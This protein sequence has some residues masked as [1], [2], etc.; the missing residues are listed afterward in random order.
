[1]ERRIVRIWSAG[2]QLPDTVSFANE[3][4]RHAEHT[5]EHIKTDATETINIGVVD[6]REETDLWRSHGVVFGEEELGL[7]HT[8]CLLC[9]YLS[10][11]LRGLNSD[12][13][14]YGDCDG[15]SIVTSK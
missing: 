4:Y 11:N 6:A 7:E 3:A 12:L 2:D 5:L 13:P 9:Q 8:T 1:M 14:S 10:R 15:P